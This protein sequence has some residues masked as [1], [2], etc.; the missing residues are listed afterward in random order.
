MEHE[1]LIEKLQEVTSDLALYMEY[2]R[3]DINALKDNPEALN[4][5]SE[6]IELLTKHNVKISTTTFAWYR[7]ILNKDKDNETSVGVN[8][9]EQLLRKEVT[10]E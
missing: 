9:I 10:H 7:F 5:I 2:N 3:C 8:I 4:F 1:Q 6:L